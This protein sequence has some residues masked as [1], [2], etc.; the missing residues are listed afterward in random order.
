MKL[1]TRYLIRQNL[2]L[3]AIILL[4]GTGLY[5]LTDLFERLDNFLIGEVGP[6]TILIFFLVKLP[7]IISAIL[8]AVYLIALVV[9]M[10]MLDR[11]RELVALSAGGISSSALVRFVIV[12]GL[13]WAVGQFLFAQVLG[14]AG[15]R[16]ATRIWQEKVRGSVLEEARIKGL[17]FTEQNRIVHIGVAYPVQQRG[18]NILVYTLDAT[19]VGIDS[20]IK[21][22]RFTIKKD[23]TWLLEKG[24]ELV[25]ARYATTAFE[26]LELPLTQDL[27]A[28]QVRSHSGNVRP[29][30]LSLLELSETIQRLERAG[31]NVESLRTAWHGK[32]AYAGSILVMG[33]LALLVTRLT[34]NIYK[35]IVLS[36]IIVFFY[37]GTNTISASM[38]DKGILMPLVGSWFANAFFFLGSTFFLAWPGLRRRL[39]R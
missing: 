25:P 27:R 7:S 16:S 19:G 37:Y 9:Q 28:F 13:I 38:A 36:L 2:F 15:E 4:M 34:S 29:N 5:V 14:V 39:W 22:E 23:D 6:G 8:P 10:N 30:Q 31:S 35:A 24:G 17:W 33:L 11:S 21:A 3:L 20:I 12:Y 26:S 32:L 1:L 18:E